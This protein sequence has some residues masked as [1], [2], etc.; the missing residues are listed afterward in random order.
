MKKPAI[1]LLLSLAPREMIFRITILFVVCLIFM[2]SPCMAQE[3]LD[4][5]PVSADSSRAPHGGI[6]K[7]SD[8]FFIEQVSEN[9]LHSFYLYDADIRP[10]SNKNLKAKAVFYFHN[11]STLAIILKPKGLNGF[12]A[13]KRNLT[14]YQ[15]CKVTVTKEG[16]KTTTEFI[17]PVYNSIKFT[18]SLHPEIIQ[19]TPGNCPRCGLELIEKKEMAKKSPDLKTE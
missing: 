13:G 19:D 11:K 17:K 12:T 8:N 9:G 7:F 10:I 14:N 16:K 18:C 15:S 1:Q 3:E 2:H 6:L 5:K 4:Y